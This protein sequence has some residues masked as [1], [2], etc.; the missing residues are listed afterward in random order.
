MKQEYIV[1]HHSVTPAELDDKKSEASFQMTHKARKFTLSR[2]GWNIGY[3]YVVYSTGLVKQYRQESESGCHTIEQKMNVRSIGI[4]LEGNFDY[5]EPT[6]AQKAAALLLITQLQEK[7]NI[8]DLKVVPHRYFATGELPN[9]TG[10]RTYTGKKPYKSC[11]G[12]KIPDNVIDYLI[13]RAP[14]ELNIPTP[15]KPWDEMAVLFSKSISASPD[16]LLHDI[17][18]YLKLAKT[19]PETFAIRTLAMQINQNPQLRTQYSN[20]IIERAKDKKPI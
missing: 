5:E 1:V 19:D 15:R 13:Q 18:E 10:W 2:L 3:H 7:Y 8:S 14:M 9:D 16:Y 12:K 11:C 6:K 17:D 20:F 4:C